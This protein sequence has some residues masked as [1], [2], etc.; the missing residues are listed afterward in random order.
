MNE[1]AALY[2]TRCCIGAM[3]AHSTYWI[4]TA[5]TCAAARSCDKAAAE[6]SQKPCGLQVIEVA[7]HS[8]LCLGGKCNDF[9]FL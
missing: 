9:Y 7:L 8:L 6:C 2:R 5:V 4:L 1:N 3:S